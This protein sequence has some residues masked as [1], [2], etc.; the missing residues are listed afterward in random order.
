M[1]EGD[2]RL[3]FEPA[4]MILASVWNY[5]DPRGPGVGDCG[6]VM[7]Q[8]TVMVACS[9]FVQVFFHTCILGTVF[10]ISLVSRKGCNRF[11]WMRLFRS[12]FYT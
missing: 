5:P 8:L 4:G 12:W 1:A 6:S 2:G 3:E 9:F 10:L 11:Y 7:W